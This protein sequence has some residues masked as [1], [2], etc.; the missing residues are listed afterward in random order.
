MH[1]IIAIEHADWYGFV[2][3][4]SFMKEF[5]FE[6][7]GVHIFLL[8]GFVSD[9]FLGIV[10]QIN[11]EMVGFAISAGSAVLDAE[12]IAFLLQKIHADISPR[13]EDA[14]LAHALY[15]YSAGGNIGHT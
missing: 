15:G 10:G 14:H 9:I 13:L 2:L 11:F 3:G 7:D 12:Q 8:R 1:G 6:L 5:E 4:N